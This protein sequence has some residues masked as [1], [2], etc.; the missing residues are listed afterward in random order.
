MKSRSL[1]AAAAV[2]LLSACNGSTSSSPFFPSNSSYVRIA[3]GSPDSGPVDV[4]IDGSVVQSNLLY[5]TMSTYV[6]INT[7]GHTVNLFKAGQDSGKALATTSFSTNSGTDT[8]VVV[9]GERNPGYGGKK[10]LGLRIFTEQPYTTP[11]GGAA[12]NFHNAAPMAPYGLHMNTIPFGYS[13]DATPANNPLGTRQPYGGSTNP[14]GLPSSALNAAITFY[15]KNYKSY[16]I[17]PGDAMPGCT[18]MPCNGQS[19]LSLYL[20]DGPAAAS[21]PPTGYPKYFSATDKMDFI[22]V[23][24]GNGLIQ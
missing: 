7:G 18:G 8:T 15:A 24:D 20:I 19:N 4:Q 10:T 1:A 12:V 23:F 3:H 6:K 14:Q 13:L 2:V 22:G 21:S 17:T 16:T 11:S 9:T 5:A